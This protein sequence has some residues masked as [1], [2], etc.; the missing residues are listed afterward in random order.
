M[1]EISDAKVLDSASVL[2]MC[3]ISIVTAQMAAM[4]KIVVRR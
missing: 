1:M 3:V 4:N 2:G